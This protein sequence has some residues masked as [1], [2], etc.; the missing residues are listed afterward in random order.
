MAMSPYASTEWRANGACTSADPD[1]FF[2][3]SDRGAAAAQIAQ[4]RRICADCT[5]RS[6]C[7]GFAM[8][9][10]EPEGIWGGTTPDERIRAW[11]EQD[12]QQPQARGSAA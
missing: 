1:L 11:R 6:R 10:R 12:A 3:I 8:E 5:V 9:A 2:P 7:L 4:A